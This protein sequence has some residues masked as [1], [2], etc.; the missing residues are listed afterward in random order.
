MNET[1]D[2]LFLV[3]G[4][5]FSFFKILFE[6]RTSQL[7]TSQQQFPSTVTF[8]VRLIPYAL[9]LIHLDLIVS[10]D[11]LILLCELIVHKWD[12]IDI[13]LIKLAM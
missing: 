4:E 9:M 10:T 5:N 3:P 8:S 1:P 13:L 6:S 11:A 7:L 2:L 12:F